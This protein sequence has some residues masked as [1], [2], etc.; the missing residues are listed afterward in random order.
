V[1]EFPVNAD[2]CQRWRIEPAA[3][4]SYSI[5]QVKTGYSLD[6]PACSEQKVDHLITWSYWNGPCQRWKL[7][8]F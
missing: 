2:D 5:Q 1:I 7:D 4:G 8:K 3:D 6:I